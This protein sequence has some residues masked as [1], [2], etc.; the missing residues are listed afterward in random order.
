MRL[1]LAAAL[2][3]QQVQAT[4]VVDRNEVELGQEILLTIT[5]EASGGNQP[6]RIVDPRLTG[7]EVQGTVDQTDVAV[8]GGTLTR[9][10]TR[11]VRLVATEVGTVTIGSVRIESGTSVV[12]TQPINIT[13]TA[14]SVAA[15]NA[16][17]PYVRDLIERRRPA[18][19]TAEEAFV[20]II[21]SADTILLGEELNLVVLAWFPRQVK[22]RL[23]NPPT[24]EPPQFRAAWTYPQ[25][26][27]GAVAQSRRIAG[28]WYDVYAHHQVVFPLTPGVFEIGSATVSYSLP[29]TYSFLSR[30]VLHEPQSR[31][32]SVEV[33]P[34]P[35]INRPRDFDG[36]SAAQ[37]EFRMEVED[38]ALS[39][40]DAG[41]VT[42]TLSGRGNV[43]LWPEPR[44]QWP[45][46]IRVYPQE[47]GIDI[48]SRDDG[49][50]GTK[51]FRY[52]VVADSYGSHVIPASNYQY[53]D[54]GALEYVTLTSGP[55]ELVTEGSPPFFTQPPMHDRPPLMDAGRLVT[56]DRVLRA[57]PVWTWI[58]VASL[59]PLIVGLV[60]LQSRLGTRAVSR[61]RTSMS[62]LERLEQRFGSVVNTLVRNPQQLDG[63]RFAEALRA[64]GV[65]APIAD[66]AARMRERLW[67]ARYG[68]EG[69]IDPD[70]LSAELEE[71]IRALRGWG[72]I[73]ERVSVVGTVV[74]LATIMGSW[75]LT[76]QSAERLYEAGAAREAA[77]SFRARARAQPLRAA[78]W[79]NL[80]SA[81]YSNGAEVPA[82]AAWLR[83]ARLEPRN[84]MISN[85]LELS[86]APD[87]TTQRMT[88]VSPITPGEAYVGALILWWLAWVLLVLRSRAR[89]IV[90]ILALCFLVGSYGLY[91]SLYYERPVA[92][93]ANDS[94]ALRVAPYGSAQN[95][96]VLERGS[97][98]LVARTEGDWVLVDR[99]RA[100]GWAR[101]QEIVLH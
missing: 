21:A 16:F 75:S 54:L 82:R 51:V 39:L 95:L 29:L 64:A 59:P 28:Q 72:P 34:Q 70:E 68:P 7:L 78:H 60:R 81:L 76:A 50:W 8:R 74:L 15:P 24:L 62:D 25:G 79:Y 38:R 49:I 33:L 63:D 55:L 6:V 46:A 14:A 61:E 71:I 48:E 56:A 12:V 37:L 83:A 26:I 18:G 43:A 88:W 87:R 73:R 91:V 65:E 17:N 11:E 85:V 44:I 10:A 2:S 58:I 66:H 31:P 42:A 22:S 98:V 99:S 101:R 40:G 41:T 67:Q 100:Q 94:T 53:F 93:I 89:A 97:A 30:E 96:S 80:G 69:G 52:L 92:L 57:W 3:M 77:D 86:P 9:I 27:P 90:S 84:R 32:A 45:D 19:V 35:S 4:A 47:V 23:R 36:A 13:V 20:E 5:V 1:L